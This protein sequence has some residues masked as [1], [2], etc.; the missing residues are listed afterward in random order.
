MFILLFFSPAT[1]Q[2]DANLDMVTSRM[3]VLVGSIKR[4]SRLYKDPM[5]AKVGPDMAQNQRGE[6]HS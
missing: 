4:R 5:A 1:S 6:G 3:E 2:K